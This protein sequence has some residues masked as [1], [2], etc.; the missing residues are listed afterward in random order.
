M[1]GNLWLLV[2][3]LIDLDFFASKDDGGSPIPFIFV[4]QGVA[5]LLLDGPRPERVLALIPSNSQYPSKL[6]LMHIQPRLEL[7]LLQGPAY[8][9]CS[10][11]I[12]K[13][14]FDLSHWDC[15]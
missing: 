15:L 7:G 1:I 8:L 12:Y 4:N 2:I 13:V 6:L 5:Y 3:I 9:L 10:L 11:L 14:F